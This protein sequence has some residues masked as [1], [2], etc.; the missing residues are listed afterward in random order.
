MRDILVHDYDEVD[1]EEVWRVVTVEVPA[2]LAAVESLL[3]EAE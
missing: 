3:A 2:Y 1:L